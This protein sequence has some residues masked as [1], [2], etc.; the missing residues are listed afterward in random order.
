M[1]ET[2]TKSKALGVFTQG[3]DRSEWKTISDLAGLGT[4][5]ADVE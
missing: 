5:A 2:R 1:R 3:L 4:S